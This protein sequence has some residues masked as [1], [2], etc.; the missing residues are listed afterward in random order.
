MHRIEL[1]AA[2][3][4]PLFDVAVF[5]DAN[6]DQIMSKSFFFLEL[7][8]LMIVWNFSCVNDTMGESIVRGAASWKTL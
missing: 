7:R 8:P 5:N 3:I 2:I 1:K 4:N 6:H